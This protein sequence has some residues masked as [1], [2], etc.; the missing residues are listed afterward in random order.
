MT[1]HTIGIEQLNE[2]VNKSLIHVDIKNHDS[3]Y[4]NEI[5]RLN[6]PFSDDEELCV[7]YRKATSNVDR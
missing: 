5:N 4:K 3:E 6:S 1:N 2:F 7:D